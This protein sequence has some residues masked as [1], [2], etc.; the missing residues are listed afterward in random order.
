MRQRGCFISQ[1]IVLILV[2]GA[3]SLPVLASLQNS[4]LGRSTRLDIP[5]AEVVDG[6]LDLVLSSDCSSEEQSGTAV[7]W[8]ACG[9]ILPPYSSD[10]EYR[11][12]IGQYSGGKVLASITLPTSQS[13]RAQLDHLSEE[14][15]AFSAREL[16]KLVKSNVRTF[17]QTQLPDL[18]RLAN[19]FEGMHFSPTLEGDLIMDPTTYEVHSR[20]VYGNQMVVII[21][22]PGSSA[23]K[24]PHPLLTWAEDLKRLLEGAAH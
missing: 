11:F 2:I 13:V 22:G 3:V 16:A 7:R 19:E 23:S 18:K 6:A 9:R 5:S 21:R 17:N 20:S 1:T 12:F 15:P 8:T 10:F 14:H 4:F 24:Q